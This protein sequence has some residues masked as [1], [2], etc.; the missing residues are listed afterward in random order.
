[1]EILCLSVG[2]WSIQESKSCFL[3]S[4][5]VLTVDFS[6]WT[7]SKLL[8]ICLVGHLIGII[9]QAWINRAGLVSVLSL[10]NL[11]GEAPQAQLWV[12]LAA[13]KPFYFFFFFFKS[14]RHSK[15]WNFFFLWLSERWHCEFRMWTDLVDEIVCVCDGAV[16]GG[17]FMMLRGGEE[18][19]LFCSGADLLPGCQVYD[20]NISLQPHNTDCTQ[21]WFVGWLV[22]QQL[23]SMVSVFG[24]RFMLMQHLY[25]SK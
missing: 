17:W 12:K 24:G 20:I 18:W 6:V 21:A 1:M 11:T 25:L 23:C 10:K 19:E 9:Q 14:L 13:F 22:L 8:H 15:S 4:H 5:F 3:C 16:A 2:Y 7:D